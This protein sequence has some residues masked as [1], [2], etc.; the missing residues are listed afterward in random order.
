MGEWENIL[1]TK[2]YTLLRGTDKKSI[3]KYSEKS[4]YP[5]EWGK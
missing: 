4:L 3:N 5:G 2:V 1:W